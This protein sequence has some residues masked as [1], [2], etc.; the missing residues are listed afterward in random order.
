[1]ARVNV[2]DTAC[3]DARLKV[4]G[5]TMSL[6]Y[7]RLGWLLIPVWSRVTEKNS[8]I[9]S[10]AT[11]SADLGKPNDLVAAGLIKGELAEYADEEHLDLSLMGGCTL[12]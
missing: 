12:R 4:A 1:M 10:L 9:V 5:K 3:H 11:L 7:Q 8:P 6:N 2:R